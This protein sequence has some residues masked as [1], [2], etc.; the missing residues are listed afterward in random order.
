MC[1]WRILACLSL[2]VAAAPMA[3]GADKAAPAA[4]P[5]TAGA[6]EIGA[7]WPQFLGPDRNNRSRE[8][9]LLKRWPKDGPKLQKTVKGLGVGFS[10]ISIAD[11]AAYTMGNHGD[12][13]LVLAFNLDSGEN[14]WKFDNAPAYHNG[15]GDGPRSTP[16]IDGDRLYALGGTGELVCLDRTSGTKIWQKNI[17][18][19]FGAGVPG[20]GICESVLIDGDRLICTPGGKDAT[21]VALDKKTGAT[22]WKAAVPQND[23]AAYASPILVDAGGVRQFVQFTARG[24]IGVRASDG[25]FLWRDDSAANG[26]ANCCA[27]VAADGMV[28]T[29]SGYGKGGSMVE[30][31]SSGDETTCRFAWHTN[32]LAV[33]HGGLVLHEGHVYGTNDQALICVD[34]RIGKVKWK[35]RCVGKGSVTFADGRLIVRSEEGPV[36]L[37]EATPAGYREAGK[38]NQPDRSG[39]K[40][41]TYPVVAAGK[42]FLRDQD[43]LLAYDL[44]GN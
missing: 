17:V 9:G 23:P 20:W 16:T 24:T 3:E 6:K 29:S 30:L 27:P 44:K 26:I 43:K 32:D 21:L 12:R 38:F 35:N 36:A 7:T 11:A 4:V 25:K 37:V 2:L 34:L 14:L 5:L 41:W 39:S 15:Y 10:N 8:S 31:S 33:H 1:V 22:V 19:D 18:K 42:L 13:E 28:F 40:A